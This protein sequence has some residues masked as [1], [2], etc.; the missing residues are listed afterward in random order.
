M[1]EATNERGFFDDCQNILGPLSEDF[2]K[3]MR[4]LPLSATFPRLTGTIFP[5]GN[6]IL[7]NCFVFLGIWLL[8]LALLSLVSEELW[9][10]S[11]LHW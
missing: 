10:L 11:F 5:A 9:F 7:S 2:W 8:V 1:S 4:A 6:I 3:V